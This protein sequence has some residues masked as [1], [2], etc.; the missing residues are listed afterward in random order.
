MHNT[1]NKGEISVLTFQ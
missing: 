1:Y